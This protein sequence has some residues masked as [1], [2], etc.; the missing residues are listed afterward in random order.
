MFAEFDKYKE[1]F[2][3]PSL[4]FPPSFVRRQLLTNHYYL[5]LLAN[6]LNKQTNGRQNSRQWEQFSCC[7]S[8]IF[9]N[10]TTLNK[11]TFQSIDYDK[12]ITIHKSYK[13]DE[14]R[15]LLAKTK[16]N[17]RKNYECASESLLIVIRHKL[18]VTVAWNVKE[19]KRVIIMNL[20][21]SVSY[22]LH[23]VNNVDISCN[24]EQ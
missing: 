20:T 1:V 19:I 2:L 10:L 23:L 16:K 18:L 7:L 9:A 6:E 21:L 15:I 4:V 3:S 11:P 12:I 8:P 22:F 13:Q 17:H 14:P 24:C 5:P